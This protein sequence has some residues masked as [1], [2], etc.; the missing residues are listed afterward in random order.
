MLLLGETC[1][2]HGP[3]LVQRFPRLLMTPASRLRSTEAGIL[4]Y[5]LAMRMSMSYRSLLSSGFRC[6][7]RET[8]KRIY[9]KET[10]GEGAILVICMEIDRCLSSEGRLNPLVISSM[11]RLVTVPCQRFEC[12]IPQRLYGKPNSTRYQ[13]TMRYQNKSMVSLVEG[14]SG[15]QGLL[16]FDAKLIPA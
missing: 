1:H 14:Q 7:T 12:W 13:V 2:D 15:L 16:K 9:H 6:L 10:L 5:H 4:I 11:L 8:E 3:S